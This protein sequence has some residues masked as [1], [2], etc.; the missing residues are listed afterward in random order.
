M[1][2]KDINIL[3]ETL[4]SEHVKKILSNLSAEE[5]FILEKSIKDLIDNFNKNILEPLKTLE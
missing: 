2:P 4:N 5:R 3:E 1:K